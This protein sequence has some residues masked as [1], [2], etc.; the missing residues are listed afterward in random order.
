MYNTNFFVQ[1]KNLLA[2]VVEKDIL[3]RL[4]C[5]MLHKWAPGKKHENTNNMAC[6]NQLT[7]NTVYL[8]KEI[9]NR[10]KNQ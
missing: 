3:W 6:Q 1:L 5:A 9:K 7:P 8:E 2:C 10:V 4:I